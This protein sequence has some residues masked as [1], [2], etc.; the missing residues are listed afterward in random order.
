MVRSEA[1]VREGD[2]PRNTVQEG[3]RIMEDTAAQRLTGAARSRRTWIF[4]GLAVLL[5]IPV[6]GAALAA[7]DSPEAD[8]ER[9]A[10]NPAAPETARRECRDPA[11][12]SADA[13]FAAAESLLA[14]GKRM[15]AFEDLQWSL[16]VDFEWPRR[17]EAGRRLFPL[18]EELADSSAGALDSPA[19]GRLES[20]FVHGYREMIQGPGGF[21]RAIEEFQECVDADSAAV[22][23]RLYLGELLVKRGDLRSALGHLMRVAELQPC[24]CRAA[25]EVGDAW[26]RLGEPMAALGWWS[27]AARDTRVPSV[28]DAALRRMSAALEARPDE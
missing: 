2:K 1:G 9:A 22:L 13:R 10:A 8:S 20:A 11:W 17:M 4:L 25:V 24:F 21:D 19:A 18:L 12:E 15:E 3:K 6:W 26:V 23:P 5:L 28:R 14:I 7:N 16:N 27:R